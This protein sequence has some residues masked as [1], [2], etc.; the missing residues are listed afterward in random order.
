MLRSSL[1]I[2]VALLAT[3]PLA[4]AAQ[5]EA[6]ALTQPAASQPPA[7][8]SA[9]TDSNA[10]RVDPAPTEDTAPTKDTTGSGDDV[11]AKNA[12]ASDADAYEQQVPTVA[13]LDQSSQA[14][15]HEILQATAE[16]LALKRAVRYPAI[17]RWTV[18]LTRAKKPEPVFRLT[19]LRLSVDGKTL[20]RQQ[21]SADQRRALRQGGADR[22]HLGTLAPGPH[23]VSISIAG[24][25]HDQPFQRTQTLTIT[26]RDGPRILWIQLDSNLVTKADG[27]RAPGV[28]VRQLEDLR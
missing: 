11:P 4:L 27:D 3:A 23:R 16:L 14:L 20:V 5:A 12:A 18:F 22:L 6:A 19:E 1:L 26:K 25:Y 8:G 28:Q 7:D 17:D 21:Y 13:E 9:A 24:Q 10:A 15:R 2:T